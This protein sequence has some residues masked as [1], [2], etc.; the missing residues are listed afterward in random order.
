MPQGNGPPAGASGIATPASRGATAGVEL[1]AALVRAA[2]G[3]E[4]DA[5]GASSGAN[6]STLSKPRGPAIRARTPPR[7]GSAAIQASY[8]CA[9]RCPAATAA[10]MA[11]GGGGDALPAQDG[12]VH[13]V[14]APCRQRRRPVKAQCAGRQLMVRRLKLPRCGL[15]GHLLVRRGFRDSY[16]RGRLLKSGGS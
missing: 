12:Q 10:S 11:P 6:A 16:G 15:P 7:N 3:G 14:L 8:G 2:R 13:G 9:R 5:L 4:Y 1:L